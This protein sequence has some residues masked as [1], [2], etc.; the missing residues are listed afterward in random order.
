MSQITLAFAVQNNQ[1]RIRVNGRATF[2]CAVDLLT[3][4]K[5]FLTKGMGI[6]LEMGGCSGMDSTFMGNLS[7]LAQQGS[8]HKLPIEISNI[9]EFN[10]KNL[11][12]LFTSALNVMF[13]FTD[14]PDNGIEWVDVEPA[15][16]SDAE[17]RQNIIDAHL[18][19]MALNEEN[20]KE[21]QD[22]V[23]IMRLEQEMDDEEKEGYVSYLL[24]PGAF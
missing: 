8:K 15:C 12:S 14:L 21:F 24:G 18:S 19:L 4:A 3:L 6:S 22:V 17:Q 11:H 20:R 16:I 2:K 9:S 1:A 23:D 5:E 10:K 13:T 7:S